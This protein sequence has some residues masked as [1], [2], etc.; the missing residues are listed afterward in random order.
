M[1]PSIDWS[2]LLNDGFLPDS[3]TESAASTDCSSPRKRRFLLTDEDKKEA[4]SRWNKV[5]KARRL[6]KM[7][8]KVTDILDT[9]SVIKNVLN[10]G[11]TQ[12]IEITNDDIVI[13]ISDIQECL[14]SLQFN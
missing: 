5:S 3:D 4:K 13:A 2:Q 8:S 11:D 10:G 7:A 9:L 1:D 14:Q 6:S 12:G